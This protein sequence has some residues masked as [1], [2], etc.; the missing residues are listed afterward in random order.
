[1]NRLFSWKSDGVVIGIALF[2]P[3]VM[4][5]IY[6]IVFAG[7]GA[8]TRFVYLGSKI[9]LGLLPVCW[10]L[11]LRYQSMRSDALTP[12]ARTVRRH[13]LSMRLGLD[14]GLFTVAAIL[15]AYYVFLKDTSLLAG[16]GAIVQGKLDDAG[17]TSLNT[18]IIMAL[19]LSILHSAFEEYY[20]RWFV[21][22]RLRTAIPWLY[23][24]LISSLG[25]ML[26][27]VIVLW[28]FLPGSYGWLMT[29]LLSLG[30]GFGGFIWCCIYQYTGSILGAWIA[31]LCADLAIM[32]IGW[33]IV[34][35]R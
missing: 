1:M 20:W 11:W 28:A 4:T 16:T 33:D 24:A 7:Q 31:H 9:V 2:A 8:F 3:M 10:F 17:V 14:F 19:F 25:F 35:S 18:F 29:L 23:A 12:P 27:H 6:F 32:W 30:I 21:F 34:V 15:V 26:H 13:E 22:G 5:W